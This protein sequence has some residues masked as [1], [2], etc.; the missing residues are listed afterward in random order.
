[1][2][3]LTPRPVP[4]VLAAPSGA[5]KTSIARGLVRSHDEYRFSVS[6]TTRQPRAGEEDGRDYH[7]VDESRFETMIQ[8]GELAEW[9]RVHGN[10]Y[11]TPRAELLRCQEAGCT[12]VLDIDVHGALQVRAGFPEALLVF[13]LPPSAEEMLRRLHLRNSEGAE[14]IRRRLDTA[15]AELERV[16]QFDYVVVNSLLDETIRTIDRIVRVEG[17]RPFRLSDLGSQVAELRRSI[18]ADLRALPIRSDSDR[19]HRQGLEPNP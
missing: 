7:F 12:P 2:I 17:R 5:G 16:E 18:E 13:V 1:M 15:L 19:E 6:A 4:L 9:A 3:T 8:A 14:E 10:L 11:G